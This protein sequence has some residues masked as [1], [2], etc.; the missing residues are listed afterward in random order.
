MGYLGTN[1][2]NWMGEGGYLNNLERDSN[3][4]YSYNKNCSNTT[5]QLILSLIVGLQTSSRPCQ[6]HFI[7]QSDIYVVAWFS[8]RHR[9]CLYFCCCYLRCEAGGLNLSI[10]LFPQGLIWEL[11]GDQYMSMPSDGNWARCVRLV[12]VVSFQ[13][14]KHPNVKHGYSTNHSL[15]LSEPF[16]CQ[17]LH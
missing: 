8:R 10:L 9:N 3:Y 14:F 12:Y 11:P 7:I 2:Q 15:R 5:W 1:G 16:D 17:G 6:L 13:K 4:Y